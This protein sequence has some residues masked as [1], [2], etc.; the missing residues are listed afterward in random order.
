MRELQLGDKILITRHTFVYPVGT[1]CEVYLP[2][3]HNDYRLNYGIRKVGNQ[4]GHALYAAWNDIHRP[5]FEE[6]FN[7]KLI[8][9]VKEHLPEWF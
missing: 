8:R 5:N 9:N 7:Y 2:K 4:T 3:Y 1:I 6:G